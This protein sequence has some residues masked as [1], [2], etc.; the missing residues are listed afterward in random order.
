MIRFERINLSGFVVVE[1]LTQQFFNIKDCE[2]EDDAF[3]RVIKALGEDG[4]IVSKNELWASPFS[5]VTAL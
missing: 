5:D 2:T 1:T 4:V 3:E